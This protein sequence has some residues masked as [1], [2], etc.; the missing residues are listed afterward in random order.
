MFAPERVLHII[1]HV[2]L[3]S[4]YLQGCV[5]LSGRS[6]PPGNA[7]AVP[8]PAGYRLARILPKFQVARAEFPA[9]DGTYAVRSRGIASDFD[10][11][12]G[13]WM[14]LNAVT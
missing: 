10:V 6:A 3:G 4:A 14:S 2:N 1:D 8:D 5:Y 12:T 7:S 9:R 13:H 11:L